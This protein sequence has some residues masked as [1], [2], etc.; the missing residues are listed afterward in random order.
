[1]R[2][3]DVIFNEEVD[4]VDEYLN[5]TNGFYC[6]NVHK[7]HISKKIKPYLLPYVCEHE[8]LHRDIGELPYF[9]I[10]GDIF[11]LL[12]LLRYI[13]NDARLKITQH[14]FNLTEDADKLY[15]YAKNNVEL[16]DNEIRKDKS[17]IAKL[18]LYKDLY[19][20]NMTLIQNCLLVQE[21]TAT[22]ISTNNP[23]VNPKIYNEF[24][25]DF[26]T[27]K[28]AELRQKLFETIGITKNNI[29]KKINND[30]YKVSY[31]Y[32]NTFCSNW[33]FEYLL[34]LAFF[35]CN[36]PYLSYDII[37]MSMREFD[38]LVNSEEYNP[39]KKWIKLGV[40]ESNK[41]EK[42]KNAIRQKSNPYGLVEE[43]LFGDDYK[44]VLLN[45]VKN[46]TDYINK[47]IF[48]NLNLQKVFPELRRF[49]RDTNLKNSKLV[50]KEFY[51]VNEE[52]EKNRNTNLINTINSII[53]YGNE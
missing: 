1:M 9:Y 32:A 12:K 5:I 22:Y 44:I 53:S 48:G 2:E 52:L 35:A 39:D 29:G 49:E 4:S 42:I 17:L 19:D 40:L 10:I 34:Q 27:M 47:Y 21:G 18:K 11:E 6:P 15:S 25:D 8:N 14:L 46:D 23:F 51:S 50:A 24:L 33:G 38:D 16:I 28:Y 3:I 31:N 37:G 45:E 41:I 20:K 43:L 26:E 7:I 36:T 30:I 13:I